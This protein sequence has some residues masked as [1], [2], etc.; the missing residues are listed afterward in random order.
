MRI[1]VVTIF[2]D[3]LAPLGLSLAG[4]AREPRAARR[5]RPRPARTGPTTGTAPSTTRPYGGGAGMVMK[6]EPWGEALDELGRR[7][8]P[9]RWSC[10]RRPASRSPRRWPAS[11]PRA[12]TW[13]SPAAATRASTSGC[14]TTPRTPAARCA[15]SRSATTCSTAARSPRWRSPRR[16]S[17]CCPGSWA[18]PSRWSRSRT[19]TGCWSTPSTPSPPSWRG[20]DVPA[21]AAVRRPRRDRRLAPRAGGA[22]HRRAPPRPAAPR[23]ALD[24]VGDPCPAGPADAGE[25]LT[26]QRACWVQEPLANDP[27]CEIPALHES[28]DDVRRVARR[29]GPRSGRAS[30]AGWSAPSA[31]GCDGERLGHRPADGRP[32]PA[33][34][35]PR[36]AAA[37][38]HRGR[39]AAERDVVRAV[40]RRAAAPTT[41]RMYKKAGYRL[42]GDLAPPPASPCVTDRSRAI[43][44]RRTGAVADSSLGPAGRRT[45]PRTHAGVCVGL[46]PQGEPRAAGHARSTPPAHRR[47]PIRFRG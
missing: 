30:P 2:P 39:R 36:P 12:S 42:R 18:T 32:R 46:L 41:M 17:G 10:R 44:P 27:A 6:P 11:W 23:A 16:S 21:G 15:R 14:S 33:G 8:A 1:D 13:C 25:L 47:D 35:R 34:P 3:Y 7:P 38:A 26:L 19:R 9:R 20:L 40:H 31:A 24:G 37:R 4:K 45:A 29:R 43:S 22:P 5:A 28:L